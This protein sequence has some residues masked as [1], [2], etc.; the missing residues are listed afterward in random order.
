MKQSYFHIQSAPALLAVLAVSFT[1]STATAGIAPEA[2]ALAQSVAAKLDT[3]QT[4]QVTA[5]HEMDPALGVGSKIENGPIQIAVKRPNQLSVV[6]YAGR[7]SRV[8][9]YDG[10]MVCVMRP[11]LKHHALEPLKADSIGK[12]ADVLDSRF[13]FRPP[14]AELLSGDL[15]TQLFLDV[16][17]ASLMG[18]E[19]VGWTQ[20][21]R[22][23]FEQKGMTGDLWVGV[24]D[25]LPRRLMFTFTDLPGNPVWNIRLSKWQ[26]NAPLDPAMFSK[27]P[28]ADSTRVQLLISR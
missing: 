24:K 25:R 13:G 20:C 18:K 11:G 4:L 23:H 12:F 17:S 9:A 2:R 16:T 19:K 5:V 8:I 28:A 1:L 14:L 3:A 27:R 7:E 22:L 15:V 21:E 10:R 26:L 6:Q